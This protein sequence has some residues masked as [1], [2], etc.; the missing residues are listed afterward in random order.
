MEILTEGRRRYG[1]RE[2]KK[3]KEK[4][5]GNGGATRGEWEDKN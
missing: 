5:K 2:K 1:K 3:V 4:R